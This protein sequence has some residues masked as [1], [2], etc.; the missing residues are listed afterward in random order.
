MNVIST[1]LL[2]TSI[3][4]ITNT[5]S[6]STKLIFNN[7]TNNTFFHSNRSSYN[8]NTSFTTKSKTKSN[9]E[10][11]SSA[12]ENNNA[13]ESTKEWNN[14][15]L[16]L[17]ENKDNSKLL[18]NKISEKL[19][20]NSRNEFNHIFS[21]TIKQLNNQ[22]SN[23]ASTT[24][25]IAQRPSNSTL[26]LVILTQTIPFIGFGLMDN[27]ILILAGDAIDTHLGVL[28]GISTLCSA[29][30]GNII[31]NNI[32]VVLGGFLEELYAKIGLPTPVLSTEQRRLRIVRIC[33]NLGII[34]GL[35]IGCVI[36]MFP[37]LF[38]HHEE[39]ERRKKE[40][41]VKDNINQIFKTMQDKKYH[42][43]MH[44][45][46]FSDII[47]SSNDTNAPI[48]DS[49]TLFLLKDDDNNSNDN[50]ND[51]TNSTTKYLFTTNPM[52]E[53]N[54]II[55]L[56][57]N[58]N[59]NFYQNLINNKKEKIALLSNDDNDTIITLNDENNNK[60]NK[61]VVGVPILNKQK[62]AIGVIQVIVQQQPTITIQDSIVLIKKIKELC[63]YTSIALSQ[64]QYRLKGD[65]KSNDVEV[66][67]LLDMIQ[68]NT[69]ST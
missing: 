50:N 59:E 43:T 11:I 37:L 21:S 41:E 68:M 1:N 5:T 35:T 58:D 7:K 22:A 48:L 17:L 16:S 24:K 60:T 61:I 40:K 63:V 10:K 62:D 51:A 57:N 4:S 42:G 56:N 55:P 66:L 18:V 52:D 14:N 46:L 26:K 20:N 2:H 47:A 23:T 31:S 64:S 44:E 27:S 3:K 25:S 69:A 15:M 67:S 65:N 39:D 45:Y 36:G 49:I 32:G 9:D 12:L 53:S 54:K 8:K 29:A 30:I 33:N 34:I 38:I 28:L 13:A 19:S 6:K